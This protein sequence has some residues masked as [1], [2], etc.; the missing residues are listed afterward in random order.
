MNWKHWLIGGDKV[1]YLI[2]AVPTA[3][4]FYLSGRVSSYMVWIFLLKC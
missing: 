3:L 2:L 4:T 1:G